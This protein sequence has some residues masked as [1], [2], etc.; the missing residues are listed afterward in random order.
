MNRKRKSRPLS[1]KELRDMFLAFNRDFFNHKINVRGTIV[2]WGTLKRDDAYGTS[3]W[4]HVISIN[5]KLRNMPVFAAQTLLHEMAHMV[6]IQAG[7]I[8]YGCDG[9]HSILFYAE[10]D[11]LYKIGAYEGLL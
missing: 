7:Y 4:K 3:S 2:Q 11:R 6:L 9:G 10:I 5:K 8:G 1:E